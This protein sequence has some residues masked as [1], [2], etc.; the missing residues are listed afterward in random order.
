MNGRIR[1]TD[2]A[3]RPMGGHARGELRRSR[4]VLNTATSRSGPVMSLVAVVTRSAGSGDLEQHGVRD[5]RR[6]EHA[7][8]LGVDSGRAC[9][10]P[11]TSCAKPQETT[12]HLQ[13]SAGH[14]HPPA[15]R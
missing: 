3:R 2:G 7:K 10:A 14:P 6:G 5:D 9:N 13:D 12:P 4:S 8:L 11:L 1:A 15:I